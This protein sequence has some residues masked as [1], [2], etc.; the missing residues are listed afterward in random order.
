MAQLDKLLGVEDSHAHPKR[1]R[2]DSAL[3]L[4]ERGMLHQAQA[5][6]DGS[7][8]DLQV[9]DKELELLDLRNSAASEVASYLYSDSAGP[10]KISPVER[11]SLNA[12]NILNY[13]ALRDPRGARVEAKRFLVRQN[14]LKDTDPD[15][16]HGAIGSYLAGFVF[17]HEGARAATV[18]DS[19][20]LY[21]VMSGLAVACLAADLYR[22]APAAV[23][24]WGR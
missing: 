17:E 24:R 5:D 16:A 23:W 3:V 4:L 9:A 20:T 18:T 11:L 2:G 14:F 10:Y 12:M 19:P 7:R 1:F 8:R 6:Y 15:H 13:L 21:A 22:H